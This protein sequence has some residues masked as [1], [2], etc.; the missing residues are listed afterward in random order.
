M[1]NPGDG[2]VDG[3][4]DCGHHT[5]DDVHR[6]Q[7]WAAHKPENAAYMEKK[8]NEVT[9]WGGGGVCDS[10]EAAVWVGA[11]VCLGGAVR[12]VMKCQPDG[13]VCM[14]VLSCMSASERLRELAQREGRR[15]PKEGLLHP[16]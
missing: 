7:K 8:P 5:E 15:K 1:S 9:W 13:S 2:W 14:S 3:A 6:K 11:L 4:K 10:R 12:R 16:Q